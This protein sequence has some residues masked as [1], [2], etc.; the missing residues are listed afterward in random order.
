[1]VVPGPD[2]MFRTPP[3][4]GVAVAGIGERL[5]GKFRPGHMAGVA[6]VVTRLLAGLQPGR[7]YFGRKDA[8]QLA[9]VARLVLD[10]GFP[11]EVVGCPLVREADGLALS[12]R[13]VLLGADRTEALTLSRGLMAAADRFDRGERRATE[14]EGAVREAV[15][16]H[17][18]EYAELCE[19][20]TMARA[21]TAEGEAVLVAAARFGSVRIIDNVRMVGAYHGARADRGVRLHHPSLL[22]GRSEP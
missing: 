7:A 2:E 10:L 3:L 14:L 11:V 12:S 20:G 17:A 4:T 8:Q 1:M 18:L 19:A 6:T 9:L 16:D 5:E 21:G 15:P 22:Y 13:N